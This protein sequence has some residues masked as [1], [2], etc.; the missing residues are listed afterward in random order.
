MQHAP[1]PGIGYLDLPTQ[2]PSDLSALSDLLFDGDYFLPLARI[3]LVDPPPGQVRLLEPLPIPDDPES[4]RELE[5]DIQLRRDLI[6]QLLIGGEPFALL[7][8]ATQFGFFTSKMLRQRFDQP[9][10]ISDPPASEWSSRFGEP[11]VVESARILQERHGDVLVAVDLSA[12]EFELLGPETRAKRLK[13]AMVASLEPV[14]EA[15]R[16]W[17]LWVDRPGERF[18][19]LARV[20]VKLGQEEQRRV[21]RAEFIR[22]CG[23]GEQ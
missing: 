19:D 2:L 12:D 9:A 23:R 3:T 5:H 16:M 18:R 1:I 4:A 22:R 21:G 7:E 20:M 8:Q 13:G 15:L 10:F 11:S 6:G 17:G 14:F